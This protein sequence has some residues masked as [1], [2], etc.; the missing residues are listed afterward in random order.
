MLTFIVGA[1]I[2]GIC[3]MSGFI[4]GLL[5]ANSKGEPPQNGA[6]KNV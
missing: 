5:M 4:M 2:G 3:Y 1:L 6:D